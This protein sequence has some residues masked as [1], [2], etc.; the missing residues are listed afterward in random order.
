[1]SKVNYCL[2]GRAVTAQ[3]SLYQQTKKSVDFLPILLYY[4]NFK[5][6]WYKQLED[7]LDRLTFDAD[8]DYRLVRAVDT[9][10]ITAADANAEKKGLSFLGN[11]NRWFYKILTNWKSNVKT[12]SFRLKKRP[13]VTC[14]VCGR[15]VGRI[16]EMHLQHYKSLSDLP[17][18]V[19]WK[20]EIFEVVT[21]PRV[22][23]TMWGKKTAKKWRAL[24]SKN[25]KEFATEKRRVRWPWR[26]KDGKRGVLCPFTK[27][28]V[29]EINDKYIQSLP[30]KFNRYATPMSW[31][32]FV[33]EHPRSLIQSE[34]YSVDRGGPTPDD[35]T[36]LGDHIGVDH[37]RS[38]SGPMDHKAVRNGEVT[39]EYEHVF[40][41]IDHTVEDKSNRQILKLIAVGYSFEDIAEELEMDRKE[42]RQRV[43]SVRDAKTDLEELL[44][45]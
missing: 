40:A 44:L 45:S 29:S 2:N 32:E 41:A 6:H 36:V 26:L 25:T 33:A 22:Y 42:V 11:F 12:S 24:A 21:G 13:A 15:R 43:R 37:R 8:F 35:G 18:F 9:F 3:V 28:V 30:D 27:R 5:D 38:A 16:D 1:M 17:K 7:Y 10:D 14:P 4:E 23:A 31:V 20:G 19:V 39:I 34:V